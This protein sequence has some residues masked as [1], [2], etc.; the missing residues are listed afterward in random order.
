MPGNEGVRRRPAPSSAIN[1]RRANRPRLAQNL[2][3]NHLAGLGTDHVG[4]VLENTASRNLGDGAGIFS[5]LGGPKGPIAPV[6]LSPP[7][8]LA[9]SMQISREVGKNSFSGID[10]NV[11]SAIRANAEIQGELELVTAHKIYSQ[12][13]EGIATNDD[14]LSRGDLIYF[15]GMDFDEAMPE[16]LAAPYVSEMAGTLANIDAQITRSKEAGNPAAVKRLEAQREE[17]LRIVQE[18]VQASLEMSTMEKAKNALAKAP[19]VKYLGADG[20]EAG[21]ED[22]ESVEIEF[23]GSIFK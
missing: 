6:A 14:I 7:P 2:P 17:I 18:K 12:I 20:K 5:S 4:G 23:E 21:P 1:N 16:L 22:F 15:G 10:V 13:Y 11:A 8:S 3:V 9:A 19:E